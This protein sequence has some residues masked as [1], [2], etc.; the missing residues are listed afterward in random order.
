MIW[1]QLANKKRTSTFNWWSL[2][3]DGN[4]TRVKL[5][6]L[7]RKLKRLSLKYPSITLTYLLN[8]TTWLIRVDIVMWMFRTKRVQSYQWIMIL[9]T[10]ALITNISKKRI[11]R[12]LVTLQLIRESG[13]AFRSVFNIVSNTLVI[14]TGIFHLNCSNCAIDDDLSAY[15]YYICHWFVLSK[16][17]RL[18]SI[19]SMLFEYLRLLCCSLSITC[20]CNSNSTIYN[21][22][23]CSASVE[24]LMSWSISDCRQWFLNWYFLRCYLIYLN[25][26]LWWWFNWSVCNFV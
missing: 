11:H 19:M 16:W 1:L 20:S 12:E 6:W 4:K 24:C 22:Y 9:W 13:V 15:I 21:R 18:C 14:L 17:W 23:N 25:F 2:D 26:C 3:R 10:N 7:R 5:N 8:S